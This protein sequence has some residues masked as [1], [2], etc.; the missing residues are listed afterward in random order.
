MSQENANSVPA[1]EP[2]TPIIAPTPAP[3]SVSTPTPSPAVAPAKVATDLHL[4]QILRE[5]NTNL[6]PY[7]F[8]NEFIPFSATC[9]VVYSCFLRTPDCYG[10][11]GKESFLCINQE[12]SC[13]KPGRNAEEYCIL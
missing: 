2:T 3:V 4:D 5:D 9:C 13:L 12:C 7:F 8:D 1:V 6:D 11:H 10:G